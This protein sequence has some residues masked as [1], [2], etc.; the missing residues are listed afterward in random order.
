MAFNIFS[1]NSFD[2]TASLSLMYLWMAFAFFTVLL[3]CDLQR[4]AFNNIYIQH[5]FAFAALF[6][7]ITIVDPNNTMSIWETW[8]KTIIIYVLFIMSTKAK[9]PF[10]AGLIAMLMIDLTIKTHIAYKEKRN[11]PIEWAKEARKY[12]RALIFVIIIA[13]FV[14][15]AFRAVKDHKKDFNWEKF[16]LG[17]G[18]CKSI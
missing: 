18:K 3:S 9:W 15:Y 7:L 8:M 1:S 2:A 14:H 16:I 17:T 6:F 12:V 4:V 10:V 13:G 5:L 11:E